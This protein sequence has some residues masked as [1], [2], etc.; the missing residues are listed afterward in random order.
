[1][2]T[3]TSTTESQVCQSVAAENAPRTIPAPVP[4]WPQTRCSPRANLAYSF[5]LALEW[6]R[7]KLRGSKHPQEPRPEFQSADPSLRNGKCR[8]EGRVAVLLCAVLLVGAVG[9]GVAQNANQFVPRYQEFSDPEGRFGNFNVGGPTDIAKNAFFQDLGTNGR[10]CV[11]CHQASDAWS[12]TP[13]H[14]QDRFNATRGMDSIFRS[15]DGSGCPTQDVSTER[16]RR[17]A[18]NLLLTK[19]LIRIEQQVPQNAEFTVL[20]NDNPY[21]C[22][23]LSAISAYRRP[24]PATNI[25][26]LSTVMWDGRETLKDANGN[27]QPINLDLAQ[28][29]KDATTGHAQGQPPT[30][31]EI[32]E[33]IDFETHI[34]TAQIRDSEA[35]DLDEDGAKGGPK[36]LSKLEFFIGINDPLGMNP[37]GAAFSPTIFSL[38][39]TWAHI[40]D[41][42]YDEHTKSR[43]AVA[44]GQKLFNTLPIP[45]TGVAGLNDALKVD[46]ING[47]CGTCHDSPNVGDHSV[48]APLN[49][50]LV[51]ASR[52]TPDLPLVT[53]MCNVTGAITQVS[54]IGRAMVTGKCADIG[55]FKGPILRGL[56]GRAPYF[57][58]GSAATL[59]DAVDF[60]DTR[61]ALHLSQ[62]DKDDLV[63]FLKTL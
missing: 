35:G 39:D 61:F 18:Y 50:G 20:N 40:D 8:Y 25:P 42:R 54:D 57:H 44:R 62:Q 10:R 11:T 63:A 60:Y 51:D 24:L 14:I 59:E 2:K 36:H 9:L 28:Q 41:R 27:F 46:T 56:A 12:V 26:Y 52:R 1:M 3:T 5:Q 21:G 47:F 29:A 48:P 55:K 49:I 15:N 33:I 58:N 7:N 4:A 31:E 6:F 30:S 13:P 16:A 43:R 22:D 32:Q 37:T 53:V 19:G 38:Y 23:S 34:F 17:S 45:I